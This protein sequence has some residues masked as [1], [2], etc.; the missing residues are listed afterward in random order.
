MKSTRKKALFQAGGIAALLAGI[1]FRRNIGAEIDL[2]TAHDFP[3][4]IQE[5]FILLHDKPFIGLSFLAIFDL[6][7]YLLVGLIFF[8]LAVALMRPHKKAAAA[9]LSLGLAGIT[10]GFTANNALPMLSLSRQYTVASGAERTTLETAAE[11]LL[12]RGGASGAFQG[13]LMT[14]SLFLIAAAGMIFAILMLRSAMF[15]KATA[16]IGILASGLDLMYCATVLLVPTL[17][18]IFI[19]AA[20]LCY[21][22]WHILVGLKLLQVSKEVRKG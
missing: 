14:L 11:A 2:F 5:W 6:V 20:G 7:N 17:A 12:A 19:A 1:L 16:I 10:A 15:N 18:V 9:A 22:I 8:A 4:S 21:M 3:A 13:S